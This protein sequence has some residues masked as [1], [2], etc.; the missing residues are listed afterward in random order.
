MK[1]VHKRA[2]LVG[3]LL[4]C[5]N[6]APVRAEVQNTA[7][8]QNLVVSVPVVDAVDVQ[9]SVT[10]QVTLASTGVRIDVPGDAAL[11]YATNGDNRVLTARLQSAPPLGIQI[12]ISLDGGLPIPLSSAS[13]TILRT[14]IHPG[15]GRFT[16]TYS[17]EA[18]TLVPGPLS[19]SVV[20]GLT[21]G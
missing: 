20:Y 5:L 7:A 2:G 4:I 21:A 6:S 12:F 15:T 3:T 17:V 8:I 18:A 19:F 1:G 10:T 9:G 13:E 16:V 14:G 11:V